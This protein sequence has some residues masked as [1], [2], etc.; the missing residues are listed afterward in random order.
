MCACAWVDVSLSV[1][2]NVQ[3]IR[4]YNAY[5]N[6]YRTRGTSKIVNAWIGHVIKG[7][8]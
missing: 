4:I 5:I 7:I 2:V 8:G 3:C 6:P 1:R